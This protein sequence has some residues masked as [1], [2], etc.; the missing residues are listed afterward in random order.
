MMAFLKALGIFAAAIFVAWICGCFKEVPSTPVHNET[1]CVW[2][3]KY[4]SLLEYDADI[5][6]RLRRDFG[7]DT[8]KKTVYAHDSIKKLHLTHGKN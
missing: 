5:S 8:T 4:D 2:K 6:N 7:V 1:E 3:K